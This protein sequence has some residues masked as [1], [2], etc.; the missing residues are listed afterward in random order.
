MRR[1]NFIFRIIFA[2]IT[3]LFCMSGNS[4]NIIEVRSNVFSG[5]Q[6][7]YNDTKLQPYQVKRLLKD[8]EPALTL[9]KK[10]RRKQTL[11]TA[12]V[13]AGNAAVTLSLVRQLQSE[14]LARDQTGQNLYLGGS[15][16][17]GLGV[18]TIF[19]A[20]KNR[21]SAFENYFGTLDSQG[22]S[23]TQVV[24]S[25]YTTFK[26]SLF[27]EGRI[28]KKKE[29]TELFK[30]YTEISQKHNTGKKVLLYG[31]VGMGVGVGVVSTS[32]AL[33]WDSR[34]GYTG[35]SIVPAAGSA[36][37]LSGI[38]TAVVGQVMMNKANIAFVKTQ[39]QSLSS[40]NSKSSDL[41]ITFGTQ[42]HGIGLGLTF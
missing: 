15:V 10:G 11:G 27:K 40:M 3:I 1:N 33:N 5:H 30:P 37:F 14:T 32:L 19:K 21:L 4:Q 16:L 6:L 34:E 23:N 35:N 42:K 39:K 26:G 22:E 9:Y 20:S 28:V 2:L 12:L 17:A 25:P 8:T 18:F 41:A 29:R 36:L 31:L 7:F 38:A 24:H 13:F